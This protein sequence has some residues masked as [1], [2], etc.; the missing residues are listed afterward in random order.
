MTDIAGP[1][2]TRS[3]TPAT[4]ERKATGLVR[5]AGTLDVLI[6]NVNFVSIGLMAVLVF[7][8]STAFYPGANLY[9]TALLTLA[10]VLPTSLVFAFFAAAMPRSGGDY[11]YVSRVLHPALGM[12]SSFNNTVWWGIYGGV[13]SA[14]FA[15]YGLGPFFKTVGQM[16]GVTWMSDVGDWVLSKPGTFVCGT[17]LIVVLV[18]L[19]IRGFGLYLRV[20]NTLF[21]ISMV[22]IVL[23]AGVWLLRSKAGFMG[24]LTA[25][26]G[27]DTMRNLDKTATA[28]GFSNG[29]PFSLKWT[30]FAGTWVYINLVFNQSSAYIGGEVKRASRLQLWS[31]PAVAC[32]STGALL[33]LLV[34][35]DHAVGLDTLGKLAAS[36]GLVFTQIAA[37][38]SGSTLIAVLLLG[39]FIFWSYT[40]LPGQIANA[41]RNLLAYSLD[42]VMPRALG[43]VHPRFHTP[44]VAL[45]VIGAASIAALA[46]F[47]WVPDFATLV[48]IFGFILGFLIVSV[49]AIA[50]PYRLPDVFE[51]SPVNGR[52]G[53][54]PWI[55]VVG[56]LSFVALAIMAYAF[57]TDPSAGLNGKPGLIALNV[58]IWLSGL[59]IYFVARAVQARKGVDISRRFKEI[60]V[61]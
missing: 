17:A 61:E 19:F 56:A 60:P 33:L 13:P 44:W 34:L 58:G 22:S 59:V 8:F 31:M 20:Q 38:G 12:M 25:G 41:S 26:V 6:Y 1:P 35:A 45:L 24:D 21:L 52:V 7:L 15:I 32:L 28:A 46:A 53:G 4:F 51:S 55:T 57:L 2:T 40:W 37:F 49:A 14:F 48:G 39:S 50:F 3:T 30:L 23:T 16:G 36:Q 42:G 54:V 29:G 27:A 5:E 9:V 47:V 18:A 43:R 10:V 11:V